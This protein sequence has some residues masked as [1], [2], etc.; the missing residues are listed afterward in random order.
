[1]VLNLQPLKFISGEFFVIGTF[2]VE[3]NIRT[4]KYIGTQFFG[5]LLI[6]NKETAAR[7]P[8]YMSILSIFMARWRYPRLWLQTPGHSCH[9][10][11]KTPGKPGVILFTQT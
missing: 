5:R 9:Q 1:M 3:K 7:V 10:K 11:R 4:Q 8:T 6:S 2:Y